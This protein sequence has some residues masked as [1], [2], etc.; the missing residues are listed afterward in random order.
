MNIKEYLLQ[1]VYLMGDD[2]L[3]NRSVI[4]YILFLCY[5]VPFKW[6][7]IICLQGRFFVRKLFYS[8]NICSSVSCAPFSRIHLRDGYKTCKNEEK[9]SNNIYL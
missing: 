5:F 3:I 4:I 1:S 6:A 8:S 9:M 7:R 2:Y